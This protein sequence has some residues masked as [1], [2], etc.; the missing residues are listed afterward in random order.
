MKR[1]G[2]AQG[3]DNGA[4]GTVHCIAGSLSYYLRQVYPNANSFQREKIKHKSIAPF[5]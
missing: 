4:Q 3:G 2:D 5:L 1:M